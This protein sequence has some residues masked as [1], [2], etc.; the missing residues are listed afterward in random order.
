MITNWLCSVILHARMQL[1]LA[2][3]GAGRLLMDKFVC[4]VCV[5]SSLQGAHLLIFLLYGAL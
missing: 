5:L 3:Y 2:C 1:Q 4:C